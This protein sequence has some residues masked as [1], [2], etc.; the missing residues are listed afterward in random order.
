MNGRRYFLDTNAIVQVLAGN[1]GLLTLLS[2]AE[3]VATSIICELEFLSFP[4]LPKED[5]LLFQRFKKRVEMIDLASD[6]LPLKD[7][8][9][10]LRSVRKLKLPDAIIAASSIVGGCTLI[11]ADRQ[12]LNMKELDAQGYA[13]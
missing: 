11:T 6:D 8:I 9:L 3:Y 12:L 5:I 13:L 1:G 2:D 10:E 4:S 7:R